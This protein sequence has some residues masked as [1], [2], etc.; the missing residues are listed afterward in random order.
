MA[1][2]Q[3]KFWIKIAHKLQSCCN[4]KTHFISFD[5]ESYD[6]IKKNGLN[7][8][9]GWKNKS[10][11][12]Y[13]ND[14]KKI[15]NIAKSNSINIE[16]FFHHEE[17]CFGFKNRDFLKKRL[18]IRFNRTQEIF[19]D[20]GLNKDT[21]IIQ[22]LG[23]YLSNLS[24]YL[25]ARD[26]SYEH[27]YIEPSFFGNRFFLLKNTY[28]CPL[29][30]KENNDNLDIISPSEK[31]KLSKAH[32]LSFL[33][34]KPVSIPKK[35]LQKY[36]NPFSRNI[37]IK[38]FKRLIEK[39]YSYLILKKHYEFGSIF[40]YSYRSL[41]EVIKSFFLEFIYTDFSEI[42]K[43]KSL[44]KKIL[45]FPLHVPN[46]MSLTIR[47]PLLFDQLL[48]CKNILNKISKNE[49]LVIKEHP[50]NVGSIK[51]LKFMK[52]AFL[53]KNFKII[54]TSISNYDITSISNKVFTINSKAG[55]EAILQGVN[56]KVLGKSFYKNYANGKNKLDLM[57]DA[58]G[59]LD[60]IYKYS[61]KGNLY[62]ELDDDIKEMFFSIKD[63]LNN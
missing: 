49:I 7:V 62:S 54:R 41:L 18:I 13:E 14:F 17:I 34:S 22:E 46:D 45:Y 15:E 8:Y 25:S 48:I 31:K 26:R 51:I 10:K 33:K 19:K 11:S 59:L 20:L 38:N 4:L 55:F 43:A 63:A 29:F 44:D 23:G 60:I 5:S 40:Y 21:I 27:F 39:L 47:E 6:L 3:T 24:I 1:R 35:D 58:E 36:K 56:T 42:I 32:K 12:N 2:Y 9:E 52:L 57:N 50:A 16:N 61:F 28:N 53:F 37:S 30:K